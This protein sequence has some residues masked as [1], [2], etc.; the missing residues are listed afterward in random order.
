MPGRRQVRCAPQALEA[1]PK[2]STRTKAP[3]GDSPRRRRS[4]R[5]GPRCGSRF[6]GGHASPAPP[7]VLGR[8]VFLYHHEVSRTRAV[9][10][11]AAHGD[12]PIRLCGRM[13]IPA[14]AL[15]RQKPRDP[16]QVGGRQDEL[17]SRQHWRNP[18]LSA[19]TSRGVLLPLQSI[20]VKA[21]RV[22]LSRPA[23]PRPQLAG[24][25]R[26]LEPAPQ[27]LFTRFLINSASARLSRAEGRLRLEPVAE[28][29]LEYHN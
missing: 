1:G 27:A 3:S 6:A 14:S 24:A 12:L 11:S 2:I 9:E 10:A 18:F 5:P 26:S 16:G 29:E 17:S 28:S 7:G 20:L 13:M 23:L 22:G 15:E 8:I 25:A 19:R 4:V 21:F